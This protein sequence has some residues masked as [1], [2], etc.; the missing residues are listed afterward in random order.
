MRL[1]CLHF[2]DAHGT[3]VLPRASHFNTLRLALG[4]TNCYGFAGDVI[5]LLGD[6][7]ESGACE[8]NAYYSLQACIN[9][10]CLPNAHAFKRDDDDDG[11]GEMVLD[12]L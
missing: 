2:E 1:S 9:H 5:E 3:P 4:L 11:R 12:I 10:S 8:G 6:N 7:G